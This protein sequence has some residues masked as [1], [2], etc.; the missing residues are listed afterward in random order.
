MMPIERGLLVLSGVFVTLAVTGWYGGTPHSLASRP[1]VSTVAD[2]GVSP[3]ESI[4]A[5]A[6][7]VSATDP[8]R[9]DRRPAS[10]AYRPELEGVAPLPKPPKPLLVLEGLVGHSALIGGVPG[11]SLTAIVSAGDTLAGLR[12]RWVGRDTVVVSDADTT[13][14]LTVRRPWH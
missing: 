11:R 8:F 14:R 2:P 10:V 12:I 4:E 6:R 5:A 7:I 1:T 13:W 9:L 3:A